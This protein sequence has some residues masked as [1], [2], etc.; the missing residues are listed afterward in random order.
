MT[1][2]RRYIL[3]L[4]AG[5]LL[6]LVSCFKQTESSGNTVSGKSIQIK[7]SDTMVNLVQSWAEEFISQH[8]DVNLGITGGGSGTGLAALLNHS[9]EIAMSS[10]SIEEKE[11]KKAE[12]SNIH[13]REFIVGLDGLMVIVH[14]SNPVD[15]LTLDQLRDIFIGK[16]NN[17]QQ[18]G[19]NNSVI[20]L[21]SRE[22]NSGTHLFFKEHILKRGDKKSKEEFSPH[23]LLMPSSQAI[24]NEVVQN[25]HT[26]GY[27]GMGYLSPRLK[28]LSVAKTAGGTFIAPSIE[29][30]VSGAYPISRP[31]YLYINGEP[32]GS[33]K[34]F[35]D[36]ALS[37]RGQTIVRETDFVPVGEYEK[38]H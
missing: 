9:C 24:V 8:P 13:P 5:A 33:I 35:I 15:G 19:G 10:R 26:I 32:A 7:G 28:A 27:V 31:L 29:N 18:V 25:P 37:L 2:N 17:W 14:P 21:L 23:A 16:V 12:E 4:M 11:L 22:S 20:V 6:S 34:A 30:V 1:A 38:N 36:F 3:I